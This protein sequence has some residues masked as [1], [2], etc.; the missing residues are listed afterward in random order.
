MAEPR[1]NARTAGVREGKSL[2]I[3]WIKSAIGYNKDQKET[4]KSLGLHRLHHTVEVPDSAS[5]RGM[6]F[7]VK[8]LV[9]VEE[10]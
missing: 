10:V 2:R 1:Q 6:V 5:I 8:H 3:T 4:I 7:K 9:T